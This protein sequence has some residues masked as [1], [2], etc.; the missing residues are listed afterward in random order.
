MSPRTRIFLLAGN[1]LLREALTRILQKRSDIVVAG[2]ALYTA[3]AIEQISDSGC[4]VLVVDSLTANLSGLEFIRNVIRAVSHLKVILIGMEE[5]EETF[6]QAVRDG[7][8]GY[9]LK[10]ASSEDVVAAVRA[11][12]KDEAVCPPRLSRA[13]FRHMHQ[14][15]TALPNI[16]ARVHL[17]LT[18]RQQQLIPLIA[19]GLTN[20]EIAGQLNLSEQTVKTHIHRMLR[21]VGVGDRLAVVEMVRGQGFVV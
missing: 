16:R 1:R 20:K 8:I 7:V 21:R 17:G 4:E 3:Q 18:R 14:E 12:A 11:A 10:D 15:S 6:L 9:V 19:Q 5:D 2:T 13:L